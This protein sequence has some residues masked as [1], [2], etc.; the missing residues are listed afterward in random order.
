M[1]RRSDLEKMTKA[2]IMDYADKHNIYLTK[3]TTKY[4]MINTLMRKTS[5]TRKRR[6][7]SPRKRRS[8]RRPKSGCIRQSTKK[9]TTRPSPPYPANRC[10]GRYMIG[11]DGSRYKSVPDSRGINRWKRV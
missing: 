7:S 8:P 9:Y 1:V 10:K 3:S 5:P 4:G 6:S 2:Q 11:N